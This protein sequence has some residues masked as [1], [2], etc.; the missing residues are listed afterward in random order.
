V[1][2]NFCELNGSPWG[3]VLEN[4]GQT[5]QLGPQHISLIA[6]GRKVK[7][8]SRNDWKDDNIYILRKLLSSL[9]GELFVGLRPGN[10]T[11][12]RHCSRGEIIVTLIRMVIAEMK[13]AFHQYILG[14]DLQDPLID[15]SAM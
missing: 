12:G 4:E 3:Q 11:K 15:R 5:G 1:T 14:I 8:Y 10:L 2:C 9:F 6:H 7:F 13:K